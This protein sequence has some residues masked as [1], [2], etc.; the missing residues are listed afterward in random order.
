VEDHL[1]AGKI[2]ESSYQLLE[3]RIEK[4]LAEIKELDSHHPEHK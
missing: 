3:K 4:Y 1:K 2:D